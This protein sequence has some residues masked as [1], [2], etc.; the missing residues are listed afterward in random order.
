MQQIRRQAQRLEPTARVARLLEATQPARA[1]LLAHPVYRSLTELSHVQRFMSHHVYAVWDFM[2]LLKALQARV[3]CVTPPWRPV[4]DPTSR[5]LINEIV[6]EEESDERS[7][8]R[9]A[10]HFEIYLEAMQEAG[11]DTRTIETF[12]RALEAGEDVAQALRVA[13]APEAAADFVQ[14]TYAGIASGQAHLVAANFAF[15]RE[16]LI[17]EMFEPMI[18]SLSDAHPGRL[19][20]LLW[21][22]RRHVQLDGELHNALATQLFVAI[23]GADD[24]RWQEA[25]DAVSESLQARLR[26]WDAVV[27]GL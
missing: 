11:A 6:L 9:Y 13:E 5:R 7:P 17:P 26:L 8:G 3:T 12:L 19:D 4:G 15:A 14:A 18:A 22:L 23:V 2:S 1:R 27:E 25:T 21:Y 16:N 24:A 10:S 20:T